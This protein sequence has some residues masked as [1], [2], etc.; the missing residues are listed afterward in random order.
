MI[1]VGTSV[2]KAGDYIEGQ[3]IELVISQQSDAAEMAA[4][5]ELLQDAMRGN[6]A[7][8]ARHDDVEE[9]RRMVDPILTDA[10]WVH[11]Y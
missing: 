3:Q 1:A 6:S 10:A 9:A 11:E 4:Y 8:F 7:R 2:N 5:E